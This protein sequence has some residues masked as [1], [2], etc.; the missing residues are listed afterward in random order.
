MA[1]CLL[2]LLAGCASILGETTTKVRL[3]V[4]PDTALICITDQFGTE[5]YHRVGA[6]VAPLKKGCGYFKRYVYTL[7][8]SA[9]GYQTRTEPLKG[10][11]SLWYG[12]GNFIFGG[13]V[14]TLI[15]DPLTGAMWDI[16]PP[17]SLTL[18]ESPPIPTAGPPIAA[19]SP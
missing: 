7:T 19:A 15:V 10:G 14:G 13:F 11:L 12:V 17:P 6:G 18:D 3:N 1:V 9:P 5:V 4:S 8:A 2:P 16:D